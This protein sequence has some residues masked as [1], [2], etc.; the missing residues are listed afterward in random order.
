[1]AGLDRK[2]SRVRA[3]GV[4]EIPE[5]DPAA[6]A[7][8]ERMTAEQI[9]DRGIRDAQVLEAFRC[10]PRHVFCAKGT[11]L[12]EA[13]SDRPLPIGNGQTISQPYMVAEMTV[14]LGVTPR[15]RVLEV[16]TGSGYQ[17]AILACLAAHVDSIERISDLA[18]TAR[19]RLAGLGLDNVTVHIG[20]GAEGLSDAAPF[21]GIV[22]TAAAPDTPPALKEQLADGARLIIPVGSRY[23]QELLIWERH[24]NRFDLHRAG[25]CRFVPLISRCA[26]SE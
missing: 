4:A 5:D 9:H 15:S 25:G 18:D 14:R 1:M 11:S 22:V 24:G 10:I 19:G 20:D 23:V 13:Y 7:L 12:W 26:W 8:R 21:D 16:G 6:R 3:V 17:T 2:E